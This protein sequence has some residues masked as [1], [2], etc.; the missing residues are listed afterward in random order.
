M[1]IWY[2][3][4]F[5]EISGKFGGAIFRKQFGKNVFQSRPL[6]G[7]R[8]KSTEKQLVREQAGRDAQAAYKIIKKDPVK[9]AEY[10]SKCPPDRRLYTFIISELLKERGKA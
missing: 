9:L 1:A 5:D 10:A 8:K 4:P 6:E 3:G 2:D 7:T